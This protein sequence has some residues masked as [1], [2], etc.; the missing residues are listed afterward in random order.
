MKI[1]STVKIIGELEAESLRIL[2]ALPGVSAVHEPLH[3]GPRVDAIIATGR[4]EQPIAVEAKSRV[5]AGTAR[6]LID[7]AESLDDLPLLVLAGQC[8]AQARALLRDHGVSVVD[9]RGSAH[10]QLPGLVLHIDGPRQTGRDAAGAGSPTRL[11]GKAGVTAQTLLADHERAWKVTDLAQEANVSTGLAHRVLTRL[12]SE[13]IC[14]SEGAGPSRVRHVQQPAAL[15]ELWAEEQRDD[16]RRTRAYLLAQTSHQ[17][18]EELAVGLER[19]GV[20]YALTGAAGATLLAPFV[21]SVRTIEVWVTATAS[22]DVLCTATGAEPVEEGHNVVFLQAKDDAP[23]TL[24]QRQ[25]EY[26]VANPFRLYVDLRRD[27]QRGREQAE[28]LRREVIGF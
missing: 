12:E 15:L 25:Q 26:W 10:V 20:A 16:P 18:V 7:L 24:R 28:H 5:N 17:T 11:S 19:A 23:L 9:A 6:Q 3:A 21:T 14:T 2:D 8:T 22:A 13:G 1:D 27:P 4:N